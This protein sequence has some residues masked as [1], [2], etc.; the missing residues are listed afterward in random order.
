MTPTL[1]YDIAIRSSSLS[2]LFDCPARWAAQHPAIGGLLSPSTV[3][4]LIGNGV[5]AGTAVFDTDRMLNITPEIG[6][7]TDAA[8]ELIRNPER[9]VS[10]DEM[11]QAKA[12]DLA[13]TLTKNYCTDVA[14]RFTF[15]VVERPMQPLDVQAKNGLRIRFTGHV[16]RRR[17]ETIDLGPHAVLETRR[18]ICDIKTGKRVVRSDGTVNTQVSGAQLAIYEL[19][20]LMAYQ[21]LK[22]PNLLPALILAMPTAGKNLVPQAAEVPHPHRVLVG[23]REN[24]GLIDMAADTIKSGNF[25][26]NPRSML[27]GPKYCPLYAK[28]R[29]RFVG[30]Q[31]VSD[32]EE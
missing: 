31:G 10:W 2:G 17:V 5:H 14:P 6:A 28:C 25:W 24:K 20:D 12:I 16:D 32:G 18:G 30:S 8:A 26:G 29:F 27:C 23:D 13:V 3:P 11:P 7:A 4:S 22:K 1:E 9:D 21:T 19:L 15:D